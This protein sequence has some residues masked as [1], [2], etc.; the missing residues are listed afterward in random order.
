MSLLIIRVEVMIGSVSICRRTVD[1]DDCK[2]FVT[3]M[4]VIFVSNLFITTITV[5]QFIHSIS[6][7]VSP[8][9]AK[10]GLP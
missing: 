5:H 10:Y 4:C 3:C 2:L 8:R 6:L 7:I 9:V 1:I